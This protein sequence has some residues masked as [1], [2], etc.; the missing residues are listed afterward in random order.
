MFEEFFNV[1]EVEFF[2]RIHT[3]EFLMNGNFSIEQLLKLQQFTE[4]KIKSQSTGKK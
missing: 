3:Q 2:G 1:E 4:K